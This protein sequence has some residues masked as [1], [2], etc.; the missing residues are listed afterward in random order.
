MD[1][2]EMMEKIMND[3]AFGDLVKNVKSGAN[4]PSEESAPQAGDRLAELLSAAPVPHG[5]ERRNALLRA[6]KPY[7]TDSR[8]E[9]IDVLTSVSKIT[10]IMDLLPHGGKDG[11]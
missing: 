1:I 6:L 9:L 10:G 3:P 4:A 2:G 5:V 8:R 7:L 11:V